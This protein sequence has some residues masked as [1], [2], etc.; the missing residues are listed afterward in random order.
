[1]PPTSIPTGLRLIG[2]L[3]LPWWFRGR[4][5]EAR[6]WLEA[7]LAAAM[8]AP[9]P[10]LAKALTWSRLL[11]DFADGTPEPPDLE[12]ELDEADRRQQRAVMLNL[13]AGD[14][15]AVAVARLQRSLTLARRALPGIASW[16]GQSS[17]R[18]SRPLRTSSN[19]TATTSAPDRCTL[20]HRS[21]RIPGRWRHRPQRTVDPG[22]DQHARKCGDRFVQE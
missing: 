17:P 19:A 4:G 6:R 12:H 3:I 16:T 7:C 2:A 20:H 11:A 22:G 1:M 15:R 13:D 21:R 10:A 14:E 18:S 8:D 5:R 9:T